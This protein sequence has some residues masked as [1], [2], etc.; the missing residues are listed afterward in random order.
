MTLYEKY[1]PSEF[2]DVLGQTKILDRIALL[3]GRE[4]LAGRAYWL[5]GPSGTGKTTLARIIAAK[6]A[7]D[8]CIDEVD[9]AGLRAG[10]VQRIEKDT[11][12]R[13]IG[14]KG[15]SIIINEAHGLSHGCVRQLLVTLERI[16]SHVV[17][18][19]TSTIDGTEGML[20]ET[21]DASPLL[22]RCIDLQLARRGL[23]DSFAERAKEIAGIEGLD[24]KDLAA[25]KK[26]V[27]RHK[28][29]FRAV[30]QSIES[31]EMI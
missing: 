12:C 27:Q 6:C 30:L 26:L 1:R 17:W 29:N 5:Q 16:P 20:F 25:Y 23:A 21:D 4:G 31:G 9:A 7:D 2:S 22:S 28:N 10:D 24:G 3:E 15:H 14:G 18:V 19:F 8:W 11:Q 13:A